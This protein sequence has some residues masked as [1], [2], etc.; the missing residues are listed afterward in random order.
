[1]DRFSD[2][3]N[4][5]NRIKSHEDS[6]SHKTCMQTLINSNDHTVK[7]IAL[8]KF[9]STEN[10]NTGLLRCVVSVIKFLL[11]HWLTFCS[12]TQILASQIMA[13]AWNFKVYCKVQ[14]FFEFLFS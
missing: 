6:A 1:M 13:T 9:C 8:C 14:F 10:G 5:S 2:R 4:I 3:K 11:S 12:D 7:L